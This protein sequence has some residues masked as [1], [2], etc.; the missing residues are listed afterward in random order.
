[1]KKILF[2]SFPAL[3]IASVAFSQKKEITAENLCKK[4]MLEKY[5]VLWTDYE[6]EASEKHDYILL[7][8]DMSYESVDEGIYGKGT[9]G[10]S[11]KGKYLLMKNNEGMLKLFIQELGNDK[12]VLIIDDK[13]LF[14]LEIHFKAEK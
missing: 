5:S 2:I 1:M 11:K 7:H 9:W 4:W 10:Y 8:P 12:L 14:D 13:E 6:P 3:L